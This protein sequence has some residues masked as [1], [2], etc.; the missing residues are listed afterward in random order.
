MSTRKIP[1]VPQIKSSW[2]LCGI[3]ATAGD[4]K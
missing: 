1:F 4:N 3:F 2:L